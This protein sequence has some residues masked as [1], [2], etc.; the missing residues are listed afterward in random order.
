VRKLIVLM[1]IA[2]LLFFGDRYVKS[3]AESKIAAELQSSFDSSG[4]A[5]VELHGFP[6]ILRVLQGSIPE[7]EITSSSLKRDGVRLTN[8]RM[9]LEDV[10]FSWSKILAGEIGSVKVGDGSGQASLEGKPLARLLGAVGGSV[11]VDGD[12]L[13]ARIGP[14]QGTARVSIDGTDL[15]FGVEGTERTLRVP[16]PRFVAGLQYRSVEID[17]AGVRISFVLTDANFRQI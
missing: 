3:K 4:D 16:L 14:V 2:V 1:S 13:V 6:F 7:A 8:V 5:S 11:S 12:R 10:E 9:D 17:G 15:I